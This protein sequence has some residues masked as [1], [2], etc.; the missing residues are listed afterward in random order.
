MYEYV[1]PIFYIFSLLLIISFIYSGKKMTCV[2]NDKS[3]WRFAALP[4]IVF[5]L[6]YGLRFGR[7][8]D[9]NLYANRYYYLGKH[10]DDEYELL[11]RYICHWGASLGIH[12]QFLIII[13]TFL[14]IFSVF[15]LFKDIKYR[16]S[17]VYIFLIFLFVINPIE[18][19]IRWYFAAAFYIFAICFYIKSDYTKFAIFS[20]CSCLT[21]VGYVPLL[22][23][24][25][26]IYY[27][28]IQLI[29]TRLCLVLFIISIFLGNTQM[30]ENLTPYLNI[31]SLNDKSTLYVDNFSTL[32]TEGSKSIG[33][34]EISFTTQIR[35]LLAYSF[36]ILFIR[37]L[38]KKGVQYW[39]INLYCISILVYPVFSKVEILDRYV[40]ILMLISVPI[41]AGMSFSLF[42]NNFRNWKIT[43]KCWGFLS[44][45]SH[46]YP[47]LI[48]FFGR[49]E[50]WYMLFIWDS[51]GR[52]SLPLFYFQQ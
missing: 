4:I 25:I 45:I 8:I 24:F 35:I 19:L 48:Y 50:W 51:N 33:I 43:I 30:L 39:I 23:L 40:S 29:P 9:Y 42:F 20:V 21:H 16:K 11:F 28:K 44:F 17:L 52:I 36:P 10:L 37:D 3:Y 31:L 47:L 32:V 38:N 27:I 34:R 13:I 12:Y 26:I 1:K 15:Y 41:I 18:Q 2:Q 5:T 49:K 7:L 46:I 22:A 6:F 14:V